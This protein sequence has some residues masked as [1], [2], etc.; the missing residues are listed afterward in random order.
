[1][2]KK[3]KKIIQFFCR[4]ST[5]EKEEVD[6][7]IIDNE[8]TEVF[9]LDPQKVALIVTENC[10]E[11]AKIDHE[12]A[13]L[14]MK[15]K[16][17]CLSKCQQQ[18]PKNIVENPTT[19]TT[20]NSADLE[21][22][23]HEII[24]VISYLQINVLMNGKS[25]EE[26]VQNANL[27]LNKTQQQQQQ[28]S[29]DMDDSKLKLFL[30]TLKTHIKSIRFQEAVQAVISLL[31]ASQHET[32][33]RALRKQYQNVDALIDKR[34]FMDILRLSETIF[35]LVIRQSGRSNP[36]VESFYCQFVS[37]RQSQYAFLLST[38]VILNSKKIETF[39][40][41]ALEAFQNELAHSDLFSKVQDDQQR[42]QESSKIESS[43]QT[44]MDPTDAFIS[45]S[46]TDMNA[47]FF[48][49]KELKFFFIIFNLP[50][51]ETAKILHKIG[52]SQP[53]QK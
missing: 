23:L 36:Y 8:T 51:T 29:V 47:S 5:M 33:Y 30:L 12:C 1:M 9:E 45:E 39:L 46:S 11:I 7:Q 4:E 48:S 52:F 18:Q 25:L 21:F 2:N 3:K 26:Y 20:I 6:T 40:G 34:Q 10:D 32:W 31:T 15:I 13:D 24:D 42:N 17:F 22:T 28:F 27:K 43:D 53:H 44:M 38:L 49:K 37:E 50:E 35:D 14:Y 41:E 19:P 16:A